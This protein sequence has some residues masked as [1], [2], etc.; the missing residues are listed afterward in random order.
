MV[1]S[2]VP[3]TVTSREKSINI[4]SISTSQLIDTIKPINL[5][6]LS[7]LRCENV[8]NK[9]QKKPQQSV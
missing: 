7:L 1:L 2:V 6:K 9:R 5:Y 4:A 8:M 3:V